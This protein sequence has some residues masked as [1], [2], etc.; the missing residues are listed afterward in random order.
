M[1]TEGNKLTGVLI[2]SLIALIAAVVGLQGER[3]ANL[4]NRVETLEERF[5]NEQEKNIDLRIALSQQNDSYEI[6]RDY[7]DSLPYPAW[8]KVV[9]QDADGSPKFVMWHIN[10]AY[11]TTFGVSKER[12]VGKTDAELGLWS[13]RVVQ[14]FYKND[15]NSYLIRDAIRTEERFPT[16][17]IDPQGSMVNGTIIKTAFD[18]EDTVAIAG[19]YLF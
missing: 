11:E 2:T 16:N 5:A 1:K 17:F 6:L 12:Y 7:L 14:D 10:P 3:E 13:D 18:F 9:R 15:Y 8:I 4:F 19:L